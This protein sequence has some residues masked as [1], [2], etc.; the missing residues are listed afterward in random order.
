MYL[1]LK[2]FFQLIL[3]KLF[4]LQVNQL[5][6]FVF[7][8][9]LLLTFSQASG[10]DTLS[11]VLRPRI[12]LGT[13]TFTYF[14]EV[15]NYQKKF[16]PLVN[17]YG[18]M[19]YVNA[20]ISK[21]FNLEFTASYGRFAANERTLTNNF[22]F[23]SRIRT[24]AVY[25]YYNFYPL[26]QSKRAMFHPFLGVGF[27]SFEFLSKTDLYDASGNM[28]YYWTDGSIMSLA[29]ND[30][31][32]P[33]N[34]VPLSRDYYYETDLRNE[35]KDSLGK[36]REQSFGFP[37]S[38]G[39]EFHLSP[40]WDFRLAATYTF[41]L[42]DLIDGISPGAIP[43][44][45]GDKSKDRLLY[46]YVSLSYDLQFGKKE[47]DL[48]DD[49]DV[50][51]YAEWD[52]ND[53]DH[54]GVIDALDDCAGT[55]LEAFVDEKGC[56]LDDDLDGV[57]N[58][59]D[60]ELDTP[61]GNYVDEYGV[62][63]TKEQ[64][65]RHWTLFN[66][67]TGYDH[68]FDEQ[69]TTVQFYKDDRVVST[70]AYKVPVGKSYVIVV[71]KDQ[72]DVGANDLYKY[73]GFSNYR[74]ITRGD[75][76]YYVL[77]DY[78]SIEEAVAAKTKLDSMGVVV[79][80]I[81]KDNV[82]NGTLTPIDTAIVHK[83]ELVNAQK[84]IYSTD[85]SIPHQVFRVQIGAFKNKIN[86]ETSFPGITV[87]S[88][89]GKDGITRYYSGNFNTY[90]EADAYKK[91]MHSKGLTN[92]FVVG[93]EDQEQ[94]TMKELGVDST[95]LG[96]NYDEQKELNTFIEPRDTAKTITPGTTIDMSK[97]K[98]RVRMAYAASAGSVSVETFSTLTSIGGIYPDVATDGSTTYYSQAF[99]SQSDA[100][101][102]MNDY[103]TY[104]L[105]DLSI[106][107][108]YEGKFYTPEEF[109]K[110]LQP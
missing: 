52:L 88:V 103:K 39:F 49:V 96:P 53:W 24:G 77:G 32:A 91:Q 51:L 90:E 4:R 69:R 68:A 36:Y 3:A 34:A 86:P 67:S 63:I 45:E 102:A 10:A 48:M 74:T 20:P 66:D 21:M 101:S 5:T 99:N 41:T 59:D 84:G 85:F 37:L 35:N 89:T 29:Q 8:T 11:S 2:S 73:L 94:K 19:L 64:F 83:V 62:T 33:T 26:F 22:N 27:S 54:D 61:H 72:K 97:V 82:N 56:P 75:T 46:S 108:E 109:K 60:D 65:D 80:L 71:G 87:I 107:V 31:L 7:A 106:R 58:F 92:A 6:K 14:G 110:L 9:W 12:G 38:F 57:P 98:Y 18:G 55:P 44:R 93:Y 78:K 43:S 104:G 15:Q 28:Y 40:R 13:G 1:L 79:E 81:G 100:E 76:V 50:P 47:T 42:T 30:P 105:E 16:S 25:L 70:S 23:E 95:K 17:R